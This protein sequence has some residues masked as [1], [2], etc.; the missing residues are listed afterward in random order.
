M[1][2]ADNPLR[3][4]QRRYRRIGAAAVVA[5]LTGL[6]TG[7]LAVGAR[8]HEIPTDVRLNAFVKPHGNRLE[9][10]VRMPM[11]ALVEV[12][13]P[14]RGPGYLEMARVE[15]ALHS[16]ARLYLVD[17]IAVIENGALLP[18]LRVAAARVALPSD[19]SFTSFDAA[20]TNVEA[21]P[22][23]DDLDLV[24]SQ[25]FL[26][27]LLDVPI[28][29]ERSE[30]A[31]RWRVDRFGRNVTTA[32]RFLPPNLGPD[33]GPDL[34][35]A[36]GVTRA[37]ELHGDP[38]LVRLD[39]RWH[40]AAGRFVAAGGWHIL[41]GLDH[42]LFLLCLVLPFRRLRP[43]LIIV[44]AFTVAHSLALVAA[45]AGF[46]PDALWFPPLIE[47]LIALTILAVAL[48]NIVRAAS[49]GRIG[50][51]A[52]DRPAGGLSQR[53]MTAFAFGI[54]HGLGFSFG[55]AEQ[56]QFAGDHLA[57]ALLAFN[58]GVEVGQIVVLA[59]A[60]PVLAW[61]LGSVV[62]EHLGIIILSALVAHTG[63]HWMLERGADL[64]RFPFQRI[65]AAFVAGT[66]RVVMALLVL[67]GA[68][69]LASSVLGRWIEDD[70]GEPGQD[71]PPGAG[72]TTC[73]HDVEIQAH[74]TH[75]NSVAP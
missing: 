38:G 12:E 65:D 50:P 30:F 44:T 17:N 62:R 48:D 18:P 9:L 3:H 71:V 68:V 47:T 66:I 2:S 52:G 36:G 29:S 6:F 67:A 61:L 39:P 23:A 46:V 22:L 33:L 74:A 1:T 21:P 15:A 53:W 54:V 28:R 69:W 56:L 26:D 58:I 51:R 55:L 14:L 35:T 8:A 13:L 75:A 25:Q 31:L 40:H 45:V 49:A 20:R 32:L 70:A 11:A 7:L 42:L 19:R 4:M 64:A 24:W 43:L 59:V 34:G 73:S 63:W 57:T 60:L 72:R 10:L 27:V 41:S 37:F 5:L 16:A